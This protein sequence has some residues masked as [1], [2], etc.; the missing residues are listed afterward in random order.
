MSIENVATD[1]ERRQPSFS[2]DRFSPD[3]RD[4]FIQTT[5]EMQ[6]KC[7]IAWSDTY[8]G[9]WVAAGNRQVFELA[10]CPHMSNDHDTAGVRR[11]YKGVTLPHPARARGVRGG[12]LEMDEP[13]HREVRAALNPY[14]SPAAV[15]RWI[16]FIDE[17]VRAGPR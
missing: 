15:N 7:P 3:Y 16:P 11:G 17:V 10:R 12:I 9:H 14:L 2:F 4:K 13:E 5:E 1:K 6:E 8:D